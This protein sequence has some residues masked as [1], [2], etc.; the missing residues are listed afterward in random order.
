[1]LFVW[2]ILQ[3]T[4]EIELSTFKSIQ[5]EDLDMDSVKATRPA[6]PILLSRLLQHVFAIFVVDL[7]SGIHFWLRHAIEP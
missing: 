2:A 5:D 6:Y 3:A 4:K 7:P 1:M